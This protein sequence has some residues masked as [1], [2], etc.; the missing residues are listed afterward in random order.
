[1]K[2]DWARLFIFFLLFFFIGDPLRELLMQGS[3]DV[4]DY[5]E[6]FKDII[7]SVSSIFVF[8]LYTVLA[9]GSL[10]YCFPRKKWI[11]C[12]VLII[13]TIILTIGVR[14]LIQQVA[15]ESL[16][17][18]VNYPKTTGLLRYS[19]DNLYYAFR[20]VG[21]GSIYYLITFSIYKE[22]REKSLS[23]A[24][25]K[26]KLS[27]LRSQLNPHFLFNSL[28]NIYSL[29]FHKSDKAPE[30]LETLSDMLRYSLYEVKEMTSVSEEVDYIKKYIRLNKLRFD[31]PI[32]IELDISEDVQDLNIPQFCLLPLVENGC[33]HGDLKDKNNPLLL[34]IRRTQEDL[35]ILVMNKK[36]THFKDET[37]GIGLENIQQRLALIYEGAHRFEVTETESTFKV[38]IKI[39]LL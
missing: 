23:Q 11:T 17:G 30:A 6:G 37:G 26:M 32:A 9:Y 35:H 18:F 20:F 29:V 24:N 4:L 34:S 27:L 14:Y 2:F 22:K 31:Y 13:S 7:L 5:E 38:D 39:P 25:H 28:N 1:M 15:F 19:R 36:N 12:I 8:F 21:F 10:Y 16:F 33:K 3:T